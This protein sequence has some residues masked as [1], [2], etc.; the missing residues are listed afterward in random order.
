MKQ[1]RWLRTTALL[2]T[3]TLVLAAC[4]GGE[5]AVAE[6][7]DGPLAGVEV[8]VGSKDF[9]EQLLLGNIL[10]QAFEQAGATVEDRVDLG[11]TQVAR[12]A[13]E[14]GEIDVYMEYNGTGWAEHLGNEV[15]P[16]NDP[17]ELTEAVRAQ[18]L[19]ENDIRWI[20]RAPFN[21]TYGFVSSPETTEANGGDGFTMHAVRRAD[22]RRVASSSSAWQVKQSSRP[23]EPMAKPTSPPCGL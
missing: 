23:E 22:A 11:G 4:G 8:T 15:A 6:E 12:S 2:S 3:L 1:R 19:E 9:D 7:G 17:K 5:E 21:N 10:V 13:L 18:D 20:G 14:S 16:S